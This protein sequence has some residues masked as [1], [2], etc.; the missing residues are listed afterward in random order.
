MRPPTTPPT[1][2]RVRCHARESVSPIVVARMNT[3]NAAITAQNHRAS[4][5]CRPANIDSAPAIVACIANR[6]VGDSASSETV[7]GPAGSGAPVLSSDSARSPV[8]AGEGQGSNAAS[9]W[10]ARVA[11]RHVAWSDGSWEAHAAT[12][13]R[14]A[15][16]AWCLARRRSTISRSPRASST[17]SRRPGFDTPAPDSSRMASARV[18]TASSRANIAPTHADTASTTA[19]VAAAAA[20][21]RLAP[22]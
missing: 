21:A 9:V 22:T 2:P 18:S 7:A 11:V 16:E 17:S 5:I 12:R 4:E 19:S 15:A 1:V 10:T 14:I 3:T 20:A 8:A 6:I 13:W